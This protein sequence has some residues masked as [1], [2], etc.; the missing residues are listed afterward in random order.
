[1]NEVLYL[2]VKYTRW[3]VLVIVL[4]YYFIDI[5]CFSGIKQRDHELDFPNT[6]LLVLY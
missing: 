4:R 2:L 3:V 6:W 5:K 1:M